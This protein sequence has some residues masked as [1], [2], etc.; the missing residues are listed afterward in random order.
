[1]RYIWPLLLL[2]SCSIYQTVTPPVHDLQQGR[3][4]A[5]QAMT[6][7]EVNN[8]SQCTDYM[9]QYLDHYKLDFSPLPYRHVWGTFQSGDYTLVAQVFAPEESRGTVFALHGYADHTGMLRHLIHHCLTQ[10]YTVA[11]YDLP[12]HGLSSGAYGSINGFTEYAGVFSDFVELCMPQVQS[13][14]YLVAHSTG[15]AVALEYLR[16][17]TQ[18]PFQKAV[19]VAPLIRHAYWYPVKWGFRFGQLTRFKTVRRKYGA[20]SSDK[21]FLTFRKEDPLAYERVPAQWVA[22]LYSWEA[23]I[24]QMDT[25]SYAGLV[26]QGTNDSVVDAPHNV[27]LLQ[28]KC[29]NLKTKWIE[30][31]RHQL[32]NESLDIRQ[33]VLDAIIEELNRISP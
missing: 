32:L 12:G 6:P 23:H 3:D 11:V 15:G 22:A 24:Q 1:V 19:L 28:R 25:L 14:Y 33:V 30:G 4:Q 7:L 31:G 17:S 20:I 21:D 27:K 2:S 5:R 10:G 29:P 13:P 9:R 18:N 16:T 26:I 8:A